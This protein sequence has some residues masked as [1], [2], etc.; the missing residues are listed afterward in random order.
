MKEIEYW[1]DQEGTKEMFSSDYWN[2][3]ENEK[4]KEWWIEDSNDKKVVNFLQKSGLLEEFTIAT[5][6][7]NLNGK[8]LDLAA[9]TCW[10]SAE[11]SKYKDVKFVDA[12]EFSH[13]RID[14]LAPLTIEFLEGVMSKI[15]RIHGS[16]YDLMLR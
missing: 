9:G 8:I 12:V 14:K 6:N 7:M 10:T 11:L 1:I 3:I 4:K 15:N 5:K 13:H 16:F 2:N